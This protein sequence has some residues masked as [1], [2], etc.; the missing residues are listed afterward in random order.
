MIKVER[1]PL[2]GKLVSYKP[3]FKTA[4]LRGHGSGRREGTIVRLALSSNQHS[5][6][7]VRNNA[8]VG[9]HT[10]LE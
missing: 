4:H 7:L 1:H 9:M 3:K 2:I 5:K 6:V 10:T 8:D